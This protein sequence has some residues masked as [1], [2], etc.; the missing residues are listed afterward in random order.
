MYKRKPETQTE[1]YLNNQTLN[2]QWKL[3]PESGE[4]HN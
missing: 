1:Q 2:K 4:S 3:P